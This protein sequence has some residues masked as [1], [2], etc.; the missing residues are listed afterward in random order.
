VIALQRTAGTRAVSQML[1]R[2]WGFPMIGAP[3]VQE[4]AKDIFEKLKKGTAPTVDEWQTMRQ[5]LSRDDFAAALAALDDFKGKAADKEAFFKT[6]KAEHV[7]LFSDFVPRK[8]GAKG[9]LDKQ[10]VDSTN[11]AR[12]IQG[13]KE[14]EDLRKK[15]DPKHARLTDGVIEML[16]WGIAE[17]RAKGSFGKEGLLG[18]D[19][20]L[21]AARGLLALSPQG[22]VVTMLKL[23]RV[24]GK[25]GWSHKRVEAVLILKAVAARTSRFSAD[26]KAALGEITGFAE[27]IR[28]EDVSKLSSQTSLRDTGGDSGLRQKYTMSCGPTSIQIVHG[29]AD[30]IYASSV[31]KTSKHSLSYQN[32]V[33]KEQEGLLVHAAAPRLLKDRYTKFLADAGAAAAGD[34]ANWGA[35]TNWMGGNAADAAKLASGKA[36]AKAKGYTDAEIA[37]F[38]KYNAGLTS[39][40]GLSVVDFQNRLTAAKLTTITNVN[41]PLKQFTKANPP[42]DAD[43]QNMWNRLWRGNDILIGVMWTGGGGHYMTLTD[44]MGDPAKGVSTRKF[45]LSD[46]WEGRSEWI[47]G[48]DLKA[49]KFGKA[50]SGWI[51]DIYY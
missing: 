2:F 18:I 28:G 8:P 17:R 45:L 33:G 46:P 41:Y 5:G 44:I 29:E 13:H 12:A 22:F 40:P 43:L 35:L 1:S 15:D 27:G 51:D 16:V 26:E 34:A 47:S 48:A 49:G 25:G 36:L 9:A 7:H 6:L 39:E 21:S 42:K 50:G 37:D 14:L 11:V 38:K 19:Q 30:P 4:A 23:A 24:G 10:V 3:T 31:S 20:A 32:T